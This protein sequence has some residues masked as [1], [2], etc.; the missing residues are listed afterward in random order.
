MT[1]HCALV[2]QTVVAKK[3]FAS[4]VLMAGRALAKRLFLLHY[5]VS[6][7]RIVLEQFS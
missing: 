4:R 3:S 2:A 7:M 1:E 6:G 5:P